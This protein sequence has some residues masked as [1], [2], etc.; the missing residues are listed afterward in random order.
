MDFIA[1]D[2]EV[3]GFVCLGICITD[4]LLWTR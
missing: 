4:G 2:L 1:T 3:T